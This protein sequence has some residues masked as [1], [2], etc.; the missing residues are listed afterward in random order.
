MRSTCSPVGN[1]GDP[2]RRGEEIAYGW[3]LA[4][5]PETAANGLSPAVVAGAPNEASTGCDDGATGIEDDDADE[6]LLDESPAVAR[7]NL[8]SGGPTL[9]ILDP[10]SSG[11]GATGIGDDDAA[12]QMLEASILIES[13]SSSSTPDCLS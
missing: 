3:T 6:R 8:L 5:D 12:E 2:L 11:D 10:S 1:L 13:A 9:C 7:R 4:V